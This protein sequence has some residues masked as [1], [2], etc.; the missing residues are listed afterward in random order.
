[1]APRVCPTPAVVSALPHEK[2]HQATHEADHEARY[3]D[4]SPPSALEHFCECS[5]RCF[6][7]ID[8]TEPV[9]AMRHPALVKGWFNRC[10]ATS[11][12]M[13]NRYFRCIGGRP[14]RGCTTC[15]RDL[16]TN[17][18]RKQTG[19]KLR[20]GETQPDPGAVHISRHAFGLVRSLTERRAAG[21]INSDE[22]RRYGGPAPSL[23]QQARPDSDP[24]ADSC[25]A[26]GPP[27]RY[28]SRLIL[29]QP[30]A[31]LLAMMC[32]NIAVRATALIGSPR[33]KATVRAVVLLCPPVMIPSGSGTIAPS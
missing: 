30:P 18:M 17:A 21:I 20:R 28:W 3:R 23:D 14:C 25:P 11:T 27:L 2:R 26:Y 24:H 13:G 15:P 8:S 32:L 5:H 31:R 19:A 33:R 1:M 10:G 22:S 29:R 7:P 9:P 4:A 6:R 16:V 12:K